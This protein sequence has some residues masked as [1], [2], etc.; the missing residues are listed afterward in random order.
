MAGQ[1]NK[2]CDRGKNCC[3]EW[4]YRNDEC[5]LWGKGREGEREWRKEREEKE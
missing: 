2:N 1:K 3:T 4:I 5:V